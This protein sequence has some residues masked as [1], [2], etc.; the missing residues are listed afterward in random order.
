MGNPNA[1]FAVSGLVTSGDVS[2]L[3]GTHAGGGASRVSHIGQIRN[4]QAE[5]E[6]GRHFDFGMILANG[7]VLEHRFRIENPSPNPLR[8][9]KA[10]AYTP[11]CS[12]VGKLPDAIPANGSAEV[13]VQFRPGYEAGSKRVEFAIRT[14]RETSPLIGLSISAMMTSALEV[15]S[16]DKGGIELPCGKPGT[17]K[18][19]VTCRR[20]E[21]EGLDA[22]TSLI[23]A[24]PLKARFLGEIR[25]EIRDGIVETKREIEIDLPAANEPG[26]K[27]A[28][29]IIRW[30]KSGRDDRR[31]IVWVVKPALK[32]T[33]TAII[34]EAG[35]TGLSIQEVIVEST[36]A[37]FRVL[38]VRGKALGIGFQPPIEKAQMHRL[39]IPIDPS[40]IGISDLNI[41]IDHPDQATIKVSILIPQ[42]SKMA[43]TTGG[44]R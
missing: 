21:K 38:A 16:T 29:L 37:E 30:G 44:A 8:L 28:D 7:Q 41:V 15:E 34:L 12:A 31:P 39:K 36:G 42:H 5:A 3:F 4:P 24:E 25:Q 35:T 10:E 1:M 19:T 6:A 32:A 9:V 23:T 22:P 40:A 2:R 18:L 43:E 17:R 11:C 27:S 26:I 14:D 20:K 13:A 33:P